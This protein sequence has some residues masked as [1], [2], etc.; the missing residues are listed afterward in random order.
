MKQFL[1]WTIGI[2][3]LAVGGAFAFRAV[4]AGR[5]RLKHALA[6][7]EAVADRTRA[8]LDETQTVLHKVRTTI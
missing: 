7:A 5:A 4:Q 1:K 8:A 3:G 2:V 6:E